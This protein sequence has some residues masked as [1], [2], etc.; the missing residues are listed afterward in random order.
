M[1]FKFLDLKVCTAA[2]KI[3]NHQLLK[4]NWYQD[5]K[6]S[7]KCCGGPELVSR[8]QNWR[9][10]MLEMLSSSILI[11]SSIQEKQQ[12]N[13]YMQSCRWWHQIL[14]F[15]DLW[16]TLKPKYLEKKIGFEICHGT[17]QL[18]RL[19]PKEIC[20]FSNVCWQTVAEGKLS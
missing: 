6:I 11:L 13:I 3:V 1:S 7:S 2:I 10:N 18:P 19:L 20:I 4:M 17:W 14:K 9:K 8:L 15:V 5:S 12:D 16:K